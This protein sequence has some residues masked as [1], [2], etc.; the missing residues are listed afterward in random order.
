MASV[1]EKKENH[2][3]FLTIDLPAEV[4]EDAL[5]RSFR[6]NANR[7]QIP[8]FRRGKAPM[9]LVTKYYGEGVLYEEAIDMA[10]NRLCRCDQGTRLTGLAAWLDILDIGRE[11][12]LKFTS[13][14]RSSLNVTLGQYL[15][16]EA[17]S[18][19]SG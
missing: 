11:K 1:L 17:S 6:K 14:S 19:S 2:Q 13:P 16:V 10:V 15:G 4:F 7:F 5:Q 12:G 18:L 8:G 3:V 9:A